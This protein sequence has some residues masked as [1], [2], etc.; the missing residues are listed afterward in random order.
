MQ[1]IPAYAT[2]VMELAHAAVLVHAIQIMLV[3]AVNFLFVM[4]SFLQIRIH[5]LV[6]VNVTGQM[7]VSAIED[8]KVKIVPLCIV[9]K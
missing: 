2:F 6:M 4:A 1:I 3:L 8:G 7:H 9:T 5:A